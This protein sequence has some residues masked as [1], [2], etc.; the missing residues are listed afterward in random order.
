MR[1][2]RPRSSRRVTPQLEARSTLANS[3]TETNDDKEGTRASAH[4]VRGVGTT[5]TIATV[6][7]LVRAA[8]QTP[9]RHRDH[10]DGADPSSPTTR[11]L[12]A[13]PPAPLDEL[14][15]GVI[16]RHARQ[17]VDRMRNPGARFPA[18]RIKACHCAFRVN[19]TKPLS[20][21]FITIDLSATCSPDQSTRS[22]ST[23]HTGRWASTR[24][25]TLDT[26]T[27]VVARRAL[28]AAF[29]SHAGVCEPPVMGTP[30][31]DFRS[32]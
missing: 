15:H 16:P 6:A 32:A 26:S 1:R 7:T 11:G 3:S 8:G 25:Q 27:H 29:R 17:S 13:P 14:R 22:A 19:A 5:A 20:L 31:P 28:H 9:G 12:T 21:G 2:H 23:A 30:S 18:A 10:D 24:S 4:R